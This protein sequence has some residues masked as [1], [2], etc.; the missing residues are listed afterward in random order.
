MGLH[1]KLVAYH[2]FPLMYK[3]QLQIIQFTMT[4]FVPSINIRVLKVIKNK[5]W[6]L[7]KRNWVHNGL[8]HIEFDS[9]AQHLMLTR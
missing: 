4:I 9:V 1:E 6:C 2:Y 3:T 7:E 8:N 5:S